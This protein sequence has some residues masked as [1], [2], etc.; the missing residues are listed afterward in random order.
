M[1]A[2]GASVV[3]G[4]V[5]V[6]AAG[7]A[8]VAGDPAHADLWRLGLVVGGA[9]VVGGAVIVYFGAEQIADAVDAK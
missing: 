5:G 8:G 3:G 1:V 6:G 4:G 2:V 7:V 9:A